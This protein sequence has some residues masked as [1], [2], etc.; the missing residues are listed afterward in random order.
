M[1]YKKKPIALAF[2]LHKVL[3]SY[4]YY[5][6]LKILSTKMPV[7]TVCSFILKPFFWLEL[8]KTSRRTR[9]LDDIFEQVE[10]KYPQAKALWSFGYE[11]SNAQKPRKHMQELLVSLKEQGYILILCSNIGPTPLSL[12]KKKYTL[13]FSL[14]DSFLTPQKS[15]GYQQKP[16]TAFFESL[17][18]LIKE[19][20]PEI[21]SIVLI[22]DRFQ[23]ITQAI[24]SGLEGILF[25]SLRMLKISLSKLYQ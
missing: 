24:N 13:F 17:K 14:F 12:L 6:A 10:K 20:Q 15:T 7:K 4:D 18:V 8:Y 23:N 21:S 11:L 19:K 22:D 1:T 2:D 25:V 16:Q 5:T 3:F 9:V